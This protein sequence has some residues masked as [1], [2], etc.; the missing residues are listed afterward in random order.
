MLASSPVRSRHQDRIKCARILLGEGKWGEIMG[1]NL[2][3]HQNVM[4]VLS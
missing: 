4:Q 3:P 1:G 2:E